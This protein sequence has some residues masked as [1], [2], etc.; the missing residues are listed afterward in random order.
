MCCALGQNTSHISHA[1]RRTRNRLQW[2]FKLQGIWIDPAYLL[3]TQG[4]GRAALCDHWVSGLPRAQS[5]TFAP[6]SHRGV[7]RRASFTITTDLFKGQRYGAPLFLYKLWLTPLA[8][9]MKAG[10][11]GYHAPV[12][13]KT[14][15]NPVQPGHPP[16][17]TC[18]HDVHFD[19]RSQVLKRERL[20]TAEDGR[21][22]SS[23]AP[24]TL[25]MAHVGLQAKL[26]QLCPRMQ[27]LRNAIG[28]VGL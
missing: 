26:H 15:S 3:A 14:V 8:S 7:G 23:Q 9:P 21:L 18:S 16:Q 4:M 1:E 17:T 19:E 13:R 27:T 24:S 12:V 20:E 5:P 25:A 28:K 2:Y 22:R 11:E 10:H 6:S